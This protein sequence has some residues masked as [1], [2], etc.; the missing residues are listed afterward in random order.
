MNAE[1][2][3]TS[4]PQGLKQGSRGFCTVLSTAGMP[5]NLAQKL[6]SLSGYR[7]LYPPKDPQAHRNPVAYS[8][9]RFPVGGRT[10]SVL[11][12]I[13]DYGLDYSD[14]TNK[15]A[16]HIA[17]D[18]PLPSSGPAA[19]LLHPGLMR[20]AWDQRCETLAEG[21][22]LPSLAVEPAV[23]RAWQALTGD[24][25]WA[26]VVAQAWLDATPKPTFLVHSEDQSPA[27]LGL[28]AEALALLPPNKRWSATF[29]TYVTTLP[30][31]VECRVRC[32]VAGSEEARMATAR[33]Q[34]IDLTKSL[35]TAPAVAGAVAARAGSMIGGSVP[36]RPDAAVAMETQSLADPQV[37]EDEDE[38]PWSDAERGPPQR[39]TAGDDEEYELQDAWAEPGSASPPQL[40]R[41][42]SKTQRVRTNAPPSFSTTPTRNLRTALIATAVSVILLSLLGGG[43]LLFWNETQQNK[44][45]PTPPAHTGSEEPVIPDESSGESQ[46]GHG[47]EEIASG[48]AVNS[49]GNA[50]ASTDEGKAALA[51][52]DWSKCTLGMRPL[53]PGDHKLLQSVPGAVFTA[54]LRSNAGEVMTLEGPGIPEHSWEW[55]RNE[56]NQWKAIADSS[57]DRYT[58]ETVD[59]GKSIRCVFRSGV[60]NQLEMES[61]A[62]NVSPIATAEVKLDVSGLVDAGVSSPFSVVQ[63]T[64]S[65]ERAPVA[66]SIESAGIG[67]EEQ[68]VFDILGGKADKFRLENSGTGVL[69]RKGKDI[70]LGLLLKPVDIQ[71]LRALLLPVHEAKKAFEKARKSLDSGVDRDIQRLNRAG[72][73]AAFQNM[74]VSIKKFLEAEMDVVDVLS[75]FESI[76]KDFLE[77]ESKNK[78]G[79]QDAV[80]KELVDRI[81]I[82]RAQTKVENVISEF[83]KSEIKTL[84]RSCVDCYQKFR[85]AADSIDGV[86]CEYGSKGS[87]R[88]SSEKKTVDDNGTNKHTVKTLGEFGFKVKIVFDKSGLAQP[89][90][91]PKPPS[92][93]TD[94]PGSPGRP[95]IG[96][97]STSG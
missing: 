43:T 74:L 50:Q 66:F 76:E 68:Y 85:S 61:P 32:V 54:E 36:S 39:S 14:R 23:C 29:S 89:V 26:G 51:P 40:R 48:N 8:H 18:A 57:A 56:D 78:K 5:I 38:D 46:G 28:L 64:S 70:S 67:S 59:L 24:A 90:P 92:S 53:N 79:E 52:F 63:S 87:I 77:Y 4:A 69:L 44:A 58:V 25:G 75:K 71:S 41:A 65:L 31:D 49:L 15:I 3:Y 88:I 80:F 83:R 11:S 45:E 93:A 37:Q 81:N 73:N 72:N 33:G 27:L 1:L 12:R 47:S 62:F 35:G 21:P 6:E 97:Q 20:T 13:S 30:P 22:R 94:H 10:L 84:L 16:H 17:V 9:L 96:L 86:V 42:K 19:L 91:G 55:Q 2:L 95:G 7:H 60:G 82:F 34:V